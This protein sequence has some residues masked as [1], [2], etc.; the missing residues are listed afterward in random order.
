MSAKITPMIQQ[1]MESEY[2]ETINAMLDAGD[3]PNTVH[4]YLESNGYVVSN[5]LVYKYAGIRTQQLLAPDKDYSGIVSE[6]ES[7]A[8]KRLLK[9]LDV[10]DMI[11][12]KGYQAIQE[13]EPADITPK[14]TMDA[15]RLKNE[16]TGG[17][18]QFLT[19][20]GYKSLRRL[21]ERKW[22]VVIQ[23][24]MT[25]IDEGRQ[26]EVQQGVEDIEEWI[27]AGTPWQDD[28]IQAKQA[29]N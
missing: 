3:S 14:L 2:A 1:L 20:R 26:A 15:I 18:H 4:K 23:Y 13:I 21:E 9:E 12:D 19:E 11:I 7:N 22:N 8:R 10:L 28:H 6:N 29:Q 25:F 17:A 27:Y 16:L 5:S 24:M